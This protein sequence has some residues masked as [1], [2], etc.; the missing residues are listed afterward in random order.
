MH[1]RVTICWGS[2]SL[3][4]SAPVLPD[5]LRLCGGSSRNS[6]EISRRVSGGK[7]PSLDRKTTDSSTKPEKALMHKGQKVMAAMSAF[8]SKVRAPEANGE[9]VLGDKDVDRE[10][11]AMLDRRNIPEHQRGK[12]RNLAMSMKKDFIKQDWAEIEAAK[13]GRPGTNNSDSSADATAGTED[14]PEVKPKRPRSRAFTL[15]RASSKEPPSPS[16]KKSEG[17][18]GRHSRSNSSDKTPSGSRSFT[19]SGAAVAQNIIAKAKGQTPDDFVSYLRKVQKPESVEVGRLHK[20]RLLL[21][22]ET[23]AWTD[24]FIGQGGMEEIV[25]L[26]HRTMEV[27]WR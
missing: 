3:C 8:G 26:L 7:R 11:E 20:L 9:R 2:G 22:N 1:L 13:N 24:E 21:R 25:G 19:S 27:E 15:S 4:L 10:F 16:K 14:V 12:M 23:V 17:T 5:L 18:M 6:A